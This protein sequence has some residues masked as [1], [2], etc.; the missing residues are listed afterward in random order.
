MA[1]FLH[2]LCIFLVLEIPWN[3]SAN[4]YQSPD[5]CL[6]TLPQPI[7]ESLSKESLNCDPL[8][9]HKSHKCMSAIVTNIQQQNGK[10]K[11]ALPNQYLR[12]FLP[13]AL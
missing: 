6:P 11:T 10:T 8:F 3:G 12:L 2:P 5:L 13:L 7:T 4:N 1:F 9:K